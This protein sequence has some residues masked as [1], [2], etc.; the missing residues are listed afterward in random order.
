VLKYILPIDEKIVM[1]AENNNR[2]FDVNGYV[3]QNN[4]LLG[5]TI[6]YNTASANHLCKTVR[7]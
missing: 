6:I 1:F 4:T 2:P 3:I 5:D 7:I